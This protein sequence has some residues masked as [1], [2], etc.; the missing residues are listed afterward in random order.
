[1][2]YRDV[3]VSQ[4]RQ[5]GITSAAF[6]NCRINGNIPA[7]SCA[8]YCVIGQNSDTG[9][10]V[11]LI[12]DTGIAD[13][14]ARSGGCKL[15]VRRRL[16]R[17]SFANIAIIATI[18][19]GDIQRVQQPVTRLAFLRGCTDRTKCLQVTVRRGLHPTTVTAGL[20]TLRA[21]LTM[22]AGVAV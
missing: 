18:H 17:L 1:M 14:R 3:T 15:R 5:V 7:L 8:C 11:Q 22:E 9:P 19:N 2:V 16:S 20:T 13:I 6:V 12:V 4:Q 21:N 10:S